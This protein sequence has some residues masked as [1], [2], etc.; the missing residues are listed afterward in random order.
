MVECKQC[1]NEFYN[2]SGNKKFCSQS[3]SCKNYYVRNKKSINA[4]HK[5]HY[6]NDKEYRFELNKK[7][8]AVKRTA[9]VIFGDKEYHHFFMNE[10][11]SLSKLRSKLTGIK[12]SV[13]HIV[14]LQNKYVS[15]LHTPDNLQIIMAI[16][17]KK[18][19]NLF[20]VGEESCQ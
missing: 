3:C 1:S 7:R 4:R 18:K 12:H 5:D 8:R 15:G 16:E 9:S 17:N 13:D 14:P 19:S 2:G 10:I 20:K 11:Y 6:N